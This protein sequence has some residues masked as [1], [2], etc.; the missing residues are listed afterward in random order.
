MVSLPS[1]NDIPRNIRS[2]LSRYGVD[3]GGVYLYLPKRARFTDEMFIQ[4]MVN[5]YSVGKGKHAILREIQGKTGWSFDY[6]RQIE[7]RL[8]QK[9]LEK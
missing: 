7:R 3:S 4:T 2:W 9:T 1:W 8:R 5:G 6:C